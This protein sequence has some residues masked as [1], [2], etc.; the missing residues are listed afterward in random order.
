[1]YGIGAFTLA[2]HSL[3]MDFLVW[4]LGGVRSETYR[5]SNLGALTNKPARTDR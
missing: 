4:W 1:M 3:G 5:H 2:L